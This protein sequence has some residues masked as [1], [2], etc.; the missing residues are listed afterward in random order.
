M[1]EQRMITNGSFT[2]KTDISDYVEHLSR[3]SQRNFHQELFTLILYN[4]AM[5]QV[6]VRTTGYCIRNKADAR[7]FTEELTAEDVADAINSRL[8]GTAGAGH[9]THNGGHRFLSAVDAIAQAVPHT[10]KVAKEKTRWRSSSAPLW[11][12]QLLSDSDS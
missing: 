8:N 2:C 9:D 5:K 4:L 7:T 12:S 10:N 3:L 1:H 6:M 11:H